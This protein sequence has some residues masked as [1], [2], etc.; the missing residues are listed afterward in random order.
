MKLGLGLRLL[1]FA[2]IYTWGFAVLALTA[3]HNMDP[4]FSI[5]PEYISGTLTASAIIFGFWAILIQERSK[6]KDKEKVHKRV[7]IVLFFFSLAT[8]I[9]SVVNIYL[10]ALDKVPP[11]V[12]LWVCLYSFLS[13]IV[14]F[15]IALYYL[16]FKEN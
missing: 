2:L 9:L 8:L 12:A 3:Y 5:E 15:T 14:N 16:Q 11:F 1:L 6:E 10:V 13:N 7:L 4:W